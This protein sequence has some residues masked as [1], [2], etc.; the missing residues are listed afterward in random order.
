[1]TAAD[2]A[3][4]PRYRWVLLGLAWLCQ[5]CVIWNWFLIPSLATE[6]Y[7]AL[8]LTQWR[9]TLIFTTP[10]MVAIVTTYLGGGLADRFGIRPT[11]F[12]AVLI[13]GVCGLTRAFTPSFAAFLGLAALLGVANSFLPPN[14]TKLVGTWFPR[15][16][17]GL[18]TGIYASAQ[19]IGFSIGLVSGP[20][21]A[22][23]RAAFLYVGLITVTVAVIWLVLGRNTPAGINVPKTEFSAGIRRALTSRNVCLAA[24]AMFLIL[25]AFQTYSAN[26]AKALVGVH[27]MSPVQAGSISSLLTWGA[28]AG[29]LLIPAIS[30]RVGVRRPFIYGGAVIA[31]TCFYL[32]WRLAP[33]GAIMFWI[34]LGGFS[35]GGM[36]PLIFS[37]PLEFPEI[38]SQYVGGSAALMNS[39][40]NLGGVL[41]PLAVTP[42]LVLENQLAYNNGF[43]VVA[44]LLALVALPVWFLLETGWR[45][46]RGQKTQDSAIAP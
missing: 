43:A 10:M 20:R 9:Y 34:M 19:A 31:A 21:F 5:L 35:L 45:A 29:T 18:A 41:V 24:V 13:S 27:G 26:L 2:E 14:L 17:I 4:Y 37:L 1:V 11:V 28:L 7:P 8:D 25:G 16:Q 30:D 46:N 12:I 15:R 38:G 42:L 32:A 3:S 22:D 33:D 36:M 23:W 6:L 44:A 39:L 40:G